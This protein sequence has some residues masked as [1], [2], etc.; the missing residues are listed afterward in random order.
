MLLCV[1]VVADM[2]RL[3][4]DVGEVAQVRNVVVGRQDHSLG[5]WNVNKSAQVNKLSNRCVN[6]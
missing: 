5:A 4:S 2:Y 6:E 1:D 3:M